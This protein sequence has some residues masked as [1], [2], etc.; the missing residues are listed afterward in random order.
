MISLTGEGG[1]EVPPS[2]KA[3]HEAM[4]LKLDIS[5]ANA[6]LHWRPVLNF[7]ET[8]EFTVAGYLDEANGNVPIYSCRQAQLEKYLQYATDQKLPV[9]NS[10]ADSFLP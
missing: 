8:V 6:L 10:H 9:A 7:R 1:Y 2:E 3:P 5:K 4:L